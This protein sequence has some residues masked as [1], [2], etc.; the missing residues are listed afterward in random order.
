MVHTA[1]RN[2]ALSCTWAADVSSFFTATTCT[3][4]PFRTCTLTEIS[5]EMQYIELPSCPQR[6]W[7]PTHKG[8]MVLLTCPFGK[9]PRY[10]RPRDP[11][12]IRFSFAKLL[13]AAWRSAIEKAVAAITVLGL[14]PELSLAWPFS[15]MPLSEGGAFKICTT[16]EALIVITSSTR[17]AVAKVQ[18]TV[19]L[20]FYTSKSQWWLFCQY[21]FDGNQSNTQSGSHT[22]NSAILSQNSTCWKM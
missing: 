1:A 15:L 11:S 16:G 2:S 5:K 14:L 18:D 22:S 3:A 10:T 8:C 17:P 13:V 20:Y 6:T 4:K 7:K 9:S 12:P 21:P 19:S